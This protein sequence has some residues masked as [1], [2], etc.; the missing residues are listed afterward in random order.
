MVGLIGL[1]IIK[2]R[3]NKETLRLVLPFIVGSF[4]LYLFLPFKSF[5][6]IGLAPIWIYAFSKLLKQSFPKAV[7]PLIIIFLTFIINSI[8]VNRVVLLQYKYAQTHNWRRKMNIDTVDWK[9]IG[10]CK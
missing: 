4:I 3:S 10:T 8:K 9:L 7:T 2:F 1:M 5:Y 6:L